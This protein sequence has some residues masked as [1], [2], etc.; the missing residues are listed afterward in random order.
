M[1]EYIYPNAV[2]YVPPNIQSSKV[3]HLPAVI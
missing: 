2:P 3:A 1:T